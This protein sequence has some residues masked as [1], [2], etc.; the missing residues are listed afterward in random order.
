MCASLASG[1]S[2]AYPTALKRRIMD[3]FGAVH[4][5]APAGEMGPCHTHD[6]PPPHW[7]PLSQ[8]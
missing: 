5:Q 4:G 7:Q 1:A 6:T 2:V 8:H 3:L